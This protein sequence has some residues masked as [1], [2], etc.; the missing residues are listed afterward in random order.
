VSL[1]STV[2]GI[3]VRFHRPATIPV[4]YLVITTGDTVDRGTSSATSQPKRGFRERS[5]LTIVASANPLSCFEE[6]QELVQWWL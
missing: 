3:V 1:Y 6:G 2:G 5:R 4:K